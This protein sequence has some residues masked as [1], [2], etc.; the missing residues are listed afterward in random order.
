MSA[1]A[2]NR[3]HRRRN[4]GARD[5]VGCGR[6]ETERRSGRRVGRCE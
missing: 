2:D 3:L 6:G 5:A 4:A 1:F